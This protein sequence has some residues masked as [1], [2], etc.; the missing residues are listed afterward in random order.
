MGRSCTAYG[1]GDTCTGFVGKPEVKGPLWR[2]RGRWECNIKKDV[3]VVDLGI[4]TGPSWISIATG[5]RHL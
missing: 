3:Q 5:G 4:W 2:H 1:G